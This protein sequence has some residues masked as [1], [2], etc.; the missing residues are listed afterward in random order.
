LK[1]EYD[2]AIQDLDLA[3]K[4]KPDYA[5][6]F[7]NRGDAYR[8][9]GDRDRAIADYKQALSLNPN[10][11]LKEDIEKALAELEPSAK[12]DAP[13]GAAPKPDGATP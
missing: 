13:D 12:P 8:G 10:D 2:K 9:K 4:L 7:R 6:A 5:R 1:G 11:A 3:I